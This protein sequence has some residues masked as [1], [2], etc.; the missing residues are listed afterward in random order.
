MQCTKVIV[1]SWFL[2][3][4]QPSISTKIL[5]LGYNAKRHLLQQLYAIAKQLEEAK[6]YT[7]V[8]NN[9]CNQQ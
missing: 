2:E 7:T 3:A 1:Q 4:L 6:L 5:E 9:C 8:Y